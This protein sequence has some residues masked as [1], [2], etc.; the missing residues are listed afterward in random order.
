MVKVPVPKEQIE[1]DKYQAAMESRNLTPRPYKEWL[2]TYK[3]SLAKDVTKANLPVDPKKVP[4]KFTKTPISNKKVPD[5]CSN[6]SVRFSWSESKR[7][8]C[9]WCEGNGT[10]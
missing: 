8:W 1:Y 10:K 6:C 4:G 5:T 2:L 3:R 9:W 7:N